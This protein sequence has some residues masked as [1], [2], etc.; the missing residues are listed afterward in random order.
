MSGAVA[1]A[2]QNENVRAAIS[3]ASDATGVDFSLLIQTAQRES[4]LNPNARANTSSATGLFQFIDSTWLDMVRRHGAEHG[5]GGYA[6]ALQSGGVDAATRRQILSLRNDP[7]IAARMAAELARENASALQARLGRAPS[8]GELYAAHVMGADGAA[9]L[10][11]A[12]A[13]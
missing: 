7:E 9:R 6:Q 1:P 4:G 10:I 13:N 5:L 12:S 3:R 11:Q 8:S 2:G